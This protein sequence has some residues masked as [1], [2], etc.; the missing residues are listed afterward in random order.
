MFGE[1]RR[2]VS[3]RWSS[4]NAETMEDKKQQQWRTKTAA[5][6]D[7]KQQQWRREKDAA[8]ATWMTQKQL[9]RWLFGRDEDG[10][11]AGSHGCSFMT[12]WGCLRSSMTGRGEED[13]EETKRGDNH[14]CR[15]LKVVVWF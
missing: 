7:K 6:E 10:V 8:A 12:A 4:G 2:V 15:S 13:N 5:M 14:G 11:A 9:R 3:R 1:D